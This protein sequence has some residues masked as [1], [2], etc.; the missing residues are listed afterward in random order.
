MDKKNDSYHAILIKELL[1][2]FIKKL[3]PQS[4]FED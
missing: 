2:I 4:A 1:K 3:D